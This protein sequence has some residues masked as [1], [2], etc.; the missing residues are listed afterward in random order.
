[1]QATAHAA[2]VWHMIEGEYQYMQQATP[3][4]V[5]QAATY[6]LPQRGVVA[7]VK[8][9]LHSMTQKPCTNTLMLA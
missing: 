5:R 7:D 8:G 9:G 1:M 4:V 6:G 2:I 3:N